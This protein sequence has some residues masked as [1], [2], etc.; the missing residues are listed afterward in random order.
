MVQVRCGVEF[1]GYKIKLAYRKRHLPECKIRSQANRS[2]ACVSQGKVEQSF[3][4]PAR[5]TAKRTMPLKT[6][7]LIVELNPLV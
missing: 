5:A 7:K 4:R 2:R 6:K 3:H 1:P